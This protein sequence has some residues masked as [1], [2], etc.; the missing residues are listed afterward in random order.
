M[1]SF[2]SLQYTVGDKKGKKAYDATLSIWDPADDKN[3]MISVTITKEWDFSRP[4]PFTLQTSQ[5]DERHVIATGPM[6]T[7]VLEFAYKEVATSLRGC[8]IDSIQGLLKIIRAFPCAICH[9]V[10]SSTSVL[11]ATASTW[12]SFSSLMKINPIAETTAWTQQ[13][14]HSPLNY[15]PD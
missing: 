8:G 6:H 5:L 14:V 11:L 3:P 2:R 15:S 1:A 10:L 13:Y 9:F 7:V 4:S 12:T